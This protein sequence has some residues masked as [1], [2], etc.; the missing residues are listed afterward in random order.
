MVVSGSESDSIY[1][2]GKGNKHNHIPRSAMN[3]FRKDKSVYNV[4]LLL[5]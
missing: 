1:L 3:K 2:I 4:S 5:L